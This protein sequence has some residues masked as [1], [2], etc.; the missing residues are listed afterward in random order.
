LHHRRQSF[1]PPLPAVVPWQ[2]GRGGGAFRGGE[3]RRI[4][5]GAR[6]RASCLTCRGMFERSSRSERSESRGTTSG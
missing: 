2:V 3:Q 6:Q 4:E 5:V 1:F